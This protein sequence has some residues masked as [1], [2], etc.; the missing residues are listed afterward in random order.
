MAVSMNISALE[1]LIKSE[2]CTCKYFAKA[3]W[4]KYRRFCIRCKG[5]KIYALAAGGYRCKRCGYTFHDFTGRWINRL[6][7][8][9]K[10]WLYV[11]KFF[12]LEIS[13]RKASMEIGISYPTVLRGY[14]S[15]RSSILADSEDWELLKGEIE[16]DEAYFGGRKKGRRGRGARG[17][18]PVFGIIERGGK[19]R[20]EVVRDVSARTLLGLAVK[21]VRRGSIVYTDRFKSYDSLMFC[22]YRHLRIDHGKR[23]ARGKVYINTLEGFWAFAKERLIK[24]HGVSRHY[25]PLYLKEMEFRYNH[26][27][28]DL[29]KLLVHYLCNLV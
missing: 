26:R 8:S 5:Y 11:I 15:I 25:F 4:K 7:I 19:V 12:E 6:R 22:G 18:T 1:S 3:C 21:R 2:S 17:K 24:F 28:Q 9:K 23:F 27:N 10:Q 20:V 16:A 29:F 14:Q 13:A